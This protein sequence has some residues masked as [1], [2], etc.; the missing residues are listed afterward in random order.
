MSYSLLDSIK[1][2]FDA[3]YYPNNKD[4]II[5]N[6][7][8]SEMPIISFPVGGLSLRIICPDFQNIPKKYGLVDNIHAHI[9]VLELANR[10]NP[11]TKDVQ[12]TCLE[13]AFRTL[14]SMVKST[15]PRESDIILLLD[16]TT[17]FKEELTTVPLAHH[18][19]DYTGGNDYAAACEYLLGRFLA[20]TQNGNRQTFTHFWDSA[21]EESNRGIRFIIAAIHDILMQRAFRDS[22]INF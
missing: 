8:F 2:I 6:V 14:D 16:G 21:L 15:C 5:S 12:A 11:R 3:D 7:H 17:C 1:R 19:P 9:L 4:I 18:F 20:I 13:A 22:S 10:D